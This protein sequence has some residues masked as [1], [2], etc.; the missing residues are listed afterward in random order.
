[1]MRGCGGGAPA[2]DDD[3]SGGDKGFGV[4]FGIKQLCCSVADCAQL[5]FRVSRRGF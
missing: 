2:D 5:R 4:I 3:D 1:M